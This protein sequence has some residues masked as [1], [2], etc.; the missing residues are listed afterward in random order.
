MSTE[1]C[2]T[3]AEKHP[4]RLHTSYGQKHRLNRRQDTDAAQGEIRVK[5]PGSH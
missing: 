4:A 5:M 1:G 2:L 3:V